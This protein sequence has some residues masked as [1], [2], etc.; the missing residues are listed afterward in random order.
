MRTMT[1]LLLVGLLAAAL[2]AAPAAAQGAV[3]GH[4]TVTDTNRCDHDF[5]VTGAEIEGSRWRFLAATSAEND[6]IITPR[7]IVLPRCFP[8]ISQ[9]PYEG[10]WNP[11]TGGC[12]PR[13]EGGGPLCL[14][15]PR[16][17]P[18]GPLHTRYTASVRVGGRTA[19]GVAD[20]IVG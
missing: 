9:A 19:T 18:A 11:A 20:L 10:T 15:N 17:S 6:A 5:A 1:R 8:D 3:A 4:A 7:I 13:T 12:I 16:T 2:P 14:E